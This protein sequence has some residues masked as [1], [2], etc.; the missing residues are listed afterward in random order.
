[1]GSRRDSTSSI[2]SA[3][4][5]V[6]TNPE[7]RVLND[8]IVEW[9]DYHGNGRNVIALRLLEIVMQLTERRAQMNAAEVESFRLYPDFV[10][11]EA[12]LHNCLLYVWGDG[13]LPMLCQREVSSICDNYFNFSNWLLMT[14]CFRV[15]F[16]LFVGSYGWSWV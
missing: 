9:R 12:M 8:A 15:N 16:Y 1:M 2:E 14:K 10:L 4:S 6:F 13:E 3:D 11:M 7:T 5:Y